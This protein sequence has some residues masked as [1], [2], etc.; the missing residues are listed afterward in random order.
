MTGKPYPVKAVH[1]HGSNPVITRANAKE[2]Y[3][4]LKQVDFLVVADLFMTPTAEL[5]DIVL[6]VATWL[7]VNYVAD[8]WKRH[9]YL[10]A[11]QKVIEVEECWPDYKIF[12]ELGK[13]M[14]QE[15]YWWDTVEGGLDYIL[16][17]SGLTWEQFKQKGYIKGEMKYR[18]YEKKGF[19]TPTRK[20]ELYSTILEGWGYDPLPTYK[21]SP[22]SPVS[23]PELL[24]EYPYILTTGRRS[25]VFFHSANRMIPWLRE[26]HPDPIVE[27]HPEV[28]EKHGIKDGDW[29]F[30]ES[31]RGKVK[32]RARLTQ[33]IDPRVVAAE[34]GWWFP[35]IATPDHGW[36]E[37][38]INILTDNALENNDV[39]VGANNLRALLCKIYPVNQEEAN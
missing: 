39:T 10:F 36:D 8:L 24:K 27:I 4:A 23:T 15:G 21:E 31:P 14:G 7:E 12:N 30:I 28:A 26:I 33:G 16:E 20:V 1:L 6:P 18:K 2:V 37:S 17:P 35:E 9:G 32:Q 38:N 11:R 13:R 3:Q 5:A 34:H 29:V 19:S 25:P 22:E